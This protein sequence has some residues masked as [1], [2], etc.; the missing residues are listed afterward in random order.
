MSVFS[1]FH[2][3]YMQTPKHNFREL[4]KLIMIVLQLQPAFK[5]KLKSIYLLVQ[6]VIHHWS[7]TIMI[8]VYFKIKFT[9]FYLKL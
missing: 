7:L 6:P 9:K 3:H 8:S 1:T 2:L 5:I 4:D